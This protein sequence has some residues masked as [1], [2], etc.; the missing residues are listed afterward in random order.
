MSKSSFLTG[1]LAIF[2][3][4]A[5]V[6]FEPFP[7]SLCTTIF[8]PIISTNFFVIA[9]P[10]PEPSI[11]MFFSKSS[12]PNFSN[13]LSISSFFIPIPLSSTEMMSL[14][15]S[16]FMIESTLNSMNPSFVYLIEFVK[17]FIHICLILVASP[18]I[19]FGISCAKLVLNSIGLS[20]RRAFDRATKLSSTSIM[21]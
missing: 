8:P 2:W 7:Y 15:T 12:L 1:S 19:Y 18:N 3:S 10:N 13:N 17:R 5:T 20:P 9:R 14:H 16:P 6:N 21:S 4:N 11:D